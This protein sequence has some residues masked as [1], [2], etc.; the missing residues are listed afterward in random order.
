[1]RFLKIIFWVF[2]FAVGAIVGDRFGVPG[3]A[4]ALPDQAWEVVR[5]QLSGNGKAS[6]Q[7]PPAQGADSPA[8]TNRERTQ[9]PD[10]ALA[11]GEASYY[12]DKLA[13]RSTAS[14][15]PYDPAKL[16]AAHRTLPFGTRLTI[17]REDTGRKV[18]VVVND[19]G[20]Y[21]AGR[22]V[23]LSRAAAEKI[24]LVADGVAEVCIYLN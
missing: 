11:C 5:A 8:E 9:A 20:P 13:G 18:R 19:R 17:V 22:I 4:R 23:D 14:G 24:D 3:W 12:S 1:M 2:L 15:E 7:A 21:T 6:S 16:T 10:K